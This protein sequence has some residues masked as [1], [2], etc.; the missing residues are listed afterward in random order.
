MKPTLRL[1]LTLAIVVGL[2][3]AQ[4]VP[5]PPSLQQQAAIQVAVELNYETDSF[6]GLM[7][8]F[9]KAER[10]YFEGRIR[11]N[12]GAVREVLVPVMDREVGEDP[13]VAL[14]RLKGLADGYAV[15]YQKF[16]AE[17]DLLP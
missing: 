6:R 13:K 5:Y 11:A 3:P 14:A 16:K 2:L 8:L 12:E 7:Y 17:V 1:F 10:V 15:A 4:S 9:P